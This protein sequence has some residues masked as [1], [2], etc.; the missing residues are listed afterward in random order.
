MENYKLR[1]D[2]V[3]LYKGEVILK[4]KKGTTELVLTN[5]NIVFIN[6]GLPFKEEITVLEYPVCSIKKYEGEPQIKV[7]GNIV[8]IYFLETEIEVVFNSK[9]ELHKFNSAAKKLLTGQT[10]IER[11]CK[12]VKD[13]IGLIDETLG[14]N[15]VQATGNVLKNGIVGNIAG[16]FGKIGK[17]VFS[18]N[19]K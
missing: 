1:S 5:L 14:I 4:N 6:K 17:S 16:A 13:S 8:E 7:N 12:N 3:V 18:K 2:E 9:T 11:V 15:T 19:K 10:S